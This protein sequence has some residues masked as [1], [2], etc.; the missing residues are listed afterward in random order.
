MRIFNLLFLAALLLGCSRGEEYEKKPNPRENNILI[1]AI[2]TP[3]DKAS[4]AK[5]TADQRT[6]DIDKEYQGLEE[7]EEERASEEYPN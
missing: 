6:S 3:L 4:E 7:E 2:R 1:K 5:L